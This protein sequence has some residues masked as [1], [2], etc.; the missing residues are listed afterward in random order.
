MRS[1]MCCKSDR[2]LVVIERVRMHSLL[3]SL[4]NFRKLYRMLGAFDIWSPSF[5]RCSGHSLLPQPARRMRR[6]CR[7]QEGSWLSWIAGD[8]SLDIAPT[9]ARP[10][11]VYQGWCATWLRSLGWISRPRLPRSVSLLCRGWPSAW[12][13]R[14][15]CIRS[16]NLTSG[17]RPRGS[18]VPWVQ[19]RSSG[20]TILCDWFCR[21]QLPA[22]S[23]E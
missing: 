12:S 23:S 21:V 2:F 1:S 20:R 8:K 7:A 11:S 6:Q 22:L 15:S 3:I 9:G 4:G 5:N 18:A 19:S 13:A 17:C 16:L 14:P 10:A